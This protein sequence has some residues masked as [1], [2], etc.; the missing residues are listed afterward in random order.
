M[1]VK[2]KSRIIVFVLA[3]LAWLSLTSFTDLQEVAAGLVTAMLVSSISGHFLITT[4]KSAS[5]IRRV[6]SF[7]N[8]LLIFIKEIIK[9]NIHVAYIVIHP[10]L[11]VK[12]GI[13][14][15]RTRLSKDSARTIL[16]NSITLTPG[17]MTIDINE[18]KNEL[19]IHWIYIR[20]D[21][22]NNIEENTEKIAGKFE[23]KLE[24]VFE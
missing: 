14:K 9:A 8:Y 22:P 1:E 2:N 19:Y 10:M 23:S 13:V 15:I 3:L 5:L 11:P 6:I 24:E 4:R 7:L 16:A 20:S 21:S 12:P 18:E 17:T